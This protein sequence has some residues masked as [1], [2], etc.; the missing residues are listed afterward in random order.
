[1]ARDPLSEVEDAPLFIVPRVLDALR[2]FR[3]AAK[4]DDLPGVDTAA[5]RARLTAALDELADRLL[6]GIERH[7]TKFWVMKQFQQTLV[8]LETED[9]EARE[10]FGMALEEI[11]DILG[12]DSSDGLLTWYP[13]G[14]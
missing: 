8:G 7:P 13:G 6:A 12:I 9:T 5:E 1:M 3:A 10:H 14:L 4:F 11:M 2:V